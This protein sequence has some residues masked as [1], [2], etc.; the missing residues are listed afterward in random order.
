V[1][2]FLQNALNRPEDIAQESVTKA[3][4]VISGE[5]FFARQHCRVLRQRSSSAD[6]L[7]QGTAMRRC[8]CVGFP[9]G[10]LQTKH[11]PLKAWGLGRVIEV[12]IAAEVVNKQAGN[13]RADFQLGVKSLVGWKKPTNRRLGPVAEG[14]GAR[15][16]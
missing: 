8:Q 5:E 11:H 7:G 14:L 3:E 1:G 6:L 2:S 4:A 15:G 13:R 10:I 9:C 12:T 16:G